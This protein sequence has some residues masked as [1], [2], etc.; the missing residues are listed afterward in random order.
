MVKAGR[1]DKAAVKAHFF[2]LV[3]PETAAGKGLRWRYKPGSYWEAR[4]R[5]DWSSC[6]DIFGLC[7]S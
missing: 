7:E 6:P 4:E 3:A 2:E 5:G 1:P